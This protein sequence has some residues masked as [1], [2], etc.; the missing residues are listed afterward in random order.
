MNE[1]E[2]RRSSGNSSARQPGRQRPR[3]GSTQHSRGQQPRRRSSGQDTSR[4]VRTAYDAGT[5]ASYRHR[6]GLEECLALEEENEREYQ[7][8]LERKRRRAIQRRREEQLRKQKIEMIKKL[9]VVGIAAV[10]LLFFGYKLFFS[11][12]VSK[13]VTVEAGTKDLKVSDF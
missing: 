1:Y 7:E 10:V 13:K 4:R 9:S 2:H 5:S 6:S 12:P 3:N 11:N 8:Y